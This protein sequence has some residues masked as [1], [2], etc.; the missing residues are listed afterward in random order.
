MLQH[1]WLKFLSVASFA[2][3]ARPPPQLRSTALGWGL[4]NFC[5]APSI[6]P[7][8]NCRSFSQ[9]LCTA[10]V[11]WLRR[12]CWLGQAGQNAQCVHGLCKRSGACFDVHGQSAVHFCDCHTLAALPTRWLA[13]LALHRQMVV[14]WTS[15]L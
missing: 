8:L 3:A 6:L 7:L 11:V 14:F 4:K 2:W 12:S 9:D 15:E 5:T 1:S 13:Q 10:M